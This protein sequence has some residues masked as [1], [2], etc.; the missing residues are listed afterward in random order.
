MNFEKR[1]QEIEQRK[2]EI[3]KLLEDENNKEINLDELETELRN[4][5]TEK[6]DIEKRMSI[7]ANIAAGKEDVKII[8]KEERKMSFAKENILETEE[9]RSAFFKR[10]LGKPLTE[11]EER[12]YTTAADSAGAVIPTQTANML[13][14]K[15]VAV[16]PMLNEITLLRVAGNVRFAVENVRDAATLH[17]E[18][19]AVNPAADSL[20]YVELAGYEYMKVIRISKSVATMS[21]NAFENWLVNMLAEDLA[22]VIEND[23]INGNGVSKPKGVEYAATWTAGSNL[24]EFT[25]GG[26][27]TFDNIMDMIAILPR[28]YHANA[29]FL[30][31]SKFLYGY[32]AKIKDDM[33]QPI[34][35][36]DFANGIQFRIMGFPVLVSDKV[37]DKTM[38]FGDFR[39]VVGNLAQDVTVES[40]VQ[41]GFLA[42]A[43]DFR[44]T[45]IFDCDIA[46][47]D[48]FTKITE[49]AV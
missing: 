10:L 18:N 25:K 38:Y 3:R 1:L 21:I 41:S 19:T 40:S 34:L 15:M 39:K 48:A 5:E 43:I 2:L 29:K 30:C 47:T 33:K 28:R 4:L 13:F 26:L 31:N 45:A 20:A 8:E 11:I 17:V 37:A 42:N 23:I 46:L 16:A 36:K 49:S 14:E 35:V 22:V 27:P 6:K 12:A 7:A 24:I 9:Y 44:G 32:L